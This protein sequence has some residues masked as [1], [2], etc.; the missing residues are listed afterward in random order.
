MIE[1]YDD[2]VEALK[3]VVTRR[4]DRATQESNLAFLDGDHWQNGETWTG[5]KPGTGAT[6]DWK[7]RIGRIFT[8]VDVVG[9][10][11]R[12]KLHASIGQIPAWTVEGANA[13][14]AKDILKSWLDL[15]EPLEL[16]ELAARH[17]QGT[18]RGVLRLYVESDTGILPTQP[19]DD[20]LEL[21]CIDVPSPLQA[22]VIGRGRRR[23]GV[24]EYESADGSKTAE[25]AHIDSDGNTVLTVFKD[26]VQIQSD[27]LPLGGQLPFYEIHDKPIL[28]NSVRRLQMA[29][30]VHSTG[31]HESGVAAAFRTLISSN[32]DLTEERID[33]VTKEKTTVSVPIT[34]GHGQWINL[35]GVE[36]DHI[37]G[38]TTYANPSVKAIDPVGTDAFE[39]R[40]DFYRRAIMHETGQDYRVSV[41]G[42]LAASTIRRLRGDFE[43]SVTPLSKRSA[44]AFK[45]MLSMVLS[46]SAAFSGEGGK[47]DGVKISVTPRIDIGD[48]LVDQQKEARS[49]HKEGFISHKTALTRYGIDDPDEEIVRVANAAGAQNDE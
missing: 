44:D 27:P 30:N 6:D 37:D 39:K 42:N 34:M 10:V 38:K 25:V 16:L 41:T 18:G 26:D 17:S 29:A 5:A 3:K 20:V 36:T 49:A 32:A 11:T 46:M 48:V 1:S 15:H 21:I 22:A 40:I 2:A 23:M 33:P 45:W 19:I 31:L 7:T 35:T 9:D 8:P 28:T 24:Y 13:E 47:F 4:I 12:A 14:A 43:N